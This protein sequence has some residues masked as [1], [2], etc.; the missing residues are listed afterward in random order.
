MIHPTDPKKSKKK[1][2]SSQDVYI[3]IKKKKK[4]LM[5]ERRSVEP[6]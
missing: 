4:M 5:G 1:E 2:G 6:E 3:P